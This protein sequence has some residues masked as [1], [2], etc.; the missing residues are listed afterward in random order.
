M[1]SF[2]ALA[3]IF[4]LICSGIFIVSAIYFIIMYTDLESDFINPID[5]CNKLNKF[6]IPEMAAHL[7]VSLILIF[8][9][10]WL[11]FL[12]N[13][14]LI[15]WNGLKISKGTHL[16]DPTEIFRNVNNEKK[17]WGIKLGFYL[18]TFFYYLYRMIVTLIAENPS[19]DSTI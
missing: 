5:L 11:S 4:G 17:E 8:A 9:G 7:V 19:V 1:A 18:F 6:I 13:L 2:S 16:L 15:I 10:N 14:P 12:F 3:F